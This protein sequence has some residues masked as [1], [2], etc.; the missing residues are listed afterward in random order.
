VAAS[1]LGIAASY[2]GDRAEARH[3]L[4]EAVVLLSGRGGADELVRA[5]FFLGCLECDDRNPTAARAR[6]KALVDGHDAVPTLPYVVGFAL[7]GLARLAAVENRCADAL[8]LAGAP[9]A[10]HSRWGTSAGRAYTAYVARGLA[11]ARRGGV[12]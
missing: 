12:R 5:Q 8:R 4:E 6:F 1:Y 11:V 7:D 2:A 10:A 3:R 9:A